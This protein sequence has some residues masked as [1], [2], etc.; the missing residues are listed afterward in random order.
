[1]TDAATG[2]N[3]GSVRILLGDDVSQLPAL[4]DHVRDL[5]PSAMDV[6]RVEDVVLT[7]DEL[8]INAA[9]HVGG[10][11][12]VDLI[13]DDDVF[14]VGVSDDDPDFRL[15]PET[16]HGERYGLRIV[17]SLSDRWSVEP[18]KAPRGGK[19]VW[20]EFD[21]GPGAR[22]DRGTDGPPTDR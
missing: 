1:M 10:D 17:D 3:P 18:L 5:A 2:G 8:V 4:L 20:A 21:L 12:V 22:S 7:V 14:R 13:V 16:P 15:T 9:H 6:A 11:I 19:V